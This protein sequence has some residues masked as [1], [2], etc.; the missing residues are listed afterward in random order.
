MEIDNPI[1]T[2]RVECKDLPMSYKYVGESFYVRDCYEKYYQDI[3]KILQREFYIS[4]TGTPGKSCLKRYRRENPD[5]TIVTASFNYSRQ[6][7]KC[8]VFEPNSEPRPEKGL[9]F[10]PIKGALHLYDGPPNMEPPDN[11]MVC[12]TSPNYDWFRSMEKEL[13]HIQLYMPTWDLDELLIANNELQLGISEEVL[14][15]RYLHVGGECSQNNGD[16]IK[17]IDSQVKLQDCLEYQGSNA[18]DLSHRIFH[19]IPSYEETDYYKVQFGSTVFLPTTYTFQI[20]SNR[21][22][23][24]ILTRIQKMNDSEREKLVEWLKGDSKSATLL[25]WLFEGFCN[26]FLKNGGELEMHKLSDNTKEVI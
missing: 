13:T 10:P 19:F 20:C 21:T 14:N 1:L 6:M 3:I 22:R 17:K 5:K 2:R 18:S 7:E 26:E 11:K 24:A 23:D 8:M 25:G 12:F 16:K 15:E 4:L 9:P